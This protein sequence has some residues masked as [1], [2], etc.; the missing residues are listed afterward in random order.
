MFEANYHPGGYDPDS[1]YSNRYGLFFPKPAQ[2]VGVIPGS[3]YG[4]RVAYVIL[5]G[6]PTPWYLQ[7]LEIV[8][9]TIDYVLAQPDRD[10][11]YLH[12]S[13]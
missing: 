1:A 7:A 2:I 5:D 12:W 13:G 10:T 8:L 6:D 9:E 3:K 11:Y 4:S